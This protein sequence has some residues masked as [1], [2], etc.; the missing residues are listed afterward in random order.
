MPYKRLKANGY[1]FVFKYEDDHPDLL[2]IYARHRK[3]PDDAIYIFFNGVAAWN[4]TYERFE[5]TLDG[6]GLFWF[7]IDKP[8][9]VVMV[10]SCFDD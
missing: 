6:E 4:T 7:W 9:K 1:T 8:G 3:E 10:V 2:H 5:T